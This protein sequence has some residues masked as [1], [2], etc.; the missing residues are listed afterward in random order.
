MAL[1][2]SRGC[3]NFRDVSVSLSLLTDGPALLPEGRL[4]RGGKLDFVTDLAEVDSPR[5]IINLR[6]GPDPVSRWPERRWVHRV[7][8]EKAGRSAVVV[9]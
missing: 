6:G 2:H 1:D 5:T 3:V 7:H 8:S 9:G 4:L